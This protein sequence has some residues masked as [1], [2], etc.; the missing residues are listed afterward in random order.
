[1]GLGQELKWLAFSLYTLSV[2]LYSP[3]NQNAIKL[4]FEETERILSLF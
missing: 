2:F 1:M 3:F 4:K